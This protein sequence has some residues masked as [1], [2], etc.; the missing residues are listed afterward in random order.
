V[1]ID[2]TEARMNTARIRR[3]RLGFGIGLRAGLVVSTL[4]LGLCAFATDGYAQTGRLK[5][6]VVDVKG[7]P[8]EGATVVMES[9]EMNR[10]L[11]TKTDK[12]GEY[13]HFL[14]PGQYVVTV[15]KDSLSQTQET[16]VSL[17]ERELNF[18]LRPGGSGGPMS[19]ADRK[20][21]EAEMAAV[22]TAFEQGATFSNEG[23]YDEAI[24]KFNEVLAKVPKCVECHTNIGLVHMKKKEFDAAEAAYKKALEV[25]PTSAEAY[26]GLSNVYNAQRKFDLATEAGAQ[27]QKLL[28]A[29]GTTAGT[30][31]GG[32]AGA[33][34]NQGVI[35]WN[36][37]KIADA[38]KLFEQAVSLDPKLA[39][40]HYWLGMAN[41]NQGKL[42]EAVKS[43]EEYLKLDPSGQ[44]VEN[45]KGMLAAIKK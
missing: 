33:V 39:D 43:F 9:K 26:M 1:N 2:Q 22:R 23:K 34:F 35:A 44:Y 37:G 5:G 16:R 11:T 4:V 8:V 21:A 20:K 15:T 42:P 19:D 38:Q 36:A 7:Q 14:P 27:A 28:G 31:G 41:V 17:D 18:T 24:A 40:A 25:N 10:K 12:R 29:S 45:A 13:T 6:K 3:T 32:S 30:G